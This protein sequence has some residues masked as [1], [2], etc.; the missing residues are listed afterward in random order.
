MLEQVVAGHHAAGKERAAHPVVIA[1]GLEG[2]AVALVRED[3]QE[4]LAALAQPAVRATEQLLPVTHV[5]K[6]LDRHDAV[7][8]TFRLEDVGVG[9]DNREVGQTAF[10][11]ACLDE[12]ALRRRVRHRSDPTHRIV[13]GHPQRQRAPAAAELKDVQ[14]VRQ[15][16]TLTGECEHGGFRL[17]KRLMPR[18]VVAR[19]VLEMLAQAL[20]EEGRRH[21]VVLL[22]GRIG[23]QRHLTGTHFLDPVLQ[24]QI[25]ARRDARFLFANAIAEQTADSPTD[26]ELRDEAAFGQLDGCAH[27]TDLGGRGKKGETLSW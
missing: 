6:H 9:G 21:F 14:A 7:V 12:L 27:Q 17:V 25:P 22:V 23:V 19:A 8:L 20:L 5:L 1:F 18:L 11:S 24:S 13:L 15:L 10:G 26:G 2:I 4:H 3:V 16:S